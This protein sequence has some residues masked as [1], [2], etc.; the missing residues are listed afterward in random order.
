MKDALAECIK[1]NYYGLYRMIAAYI[2][3]KIEVQTAGKVVNSY[4]QVENLEAAKMHQNKHSMSNIVK[5][6]SPL[7]CIMMKINEM[8][9]DFTFTLSPK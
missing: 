2:P 7:F 8:E 5:K 3:D 6:N 1:N 4:S 9:D